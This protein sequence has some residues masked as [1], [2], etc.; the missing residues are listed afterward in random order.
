MKTNT[1]LIGLFY[2]DIKCNR[3]GKNEIEVTRKIYIY[4]ILG[5]EREILILRHIQG[6][7]LPESKYIIARKFL[8]VFAIVCYTQECRCVC[9]LP[10]S[11]V[12]RI[13]I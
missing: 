2:T 10:N 5:S 1:L 11:T 12:L 8:C 7:S 6:L 13:R 9:Y 4:M 3:S